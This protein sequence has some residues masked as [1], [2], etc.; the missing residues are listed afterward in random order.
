MAALDWLASQSVSSTT[1]TEYR[2][3]LFFRIYFLQKRLAIIE[4]EKN[5]KYDNNDG[6]ILNV[7]FPFWL[8]VGKLKG[9][10]IIVGII[11]CCRARK[12]ANRWSKK[13]IVKF[14]TP[15]SFMTKIKFN[16]VSKSGD[17]F[18]LRKRNPKRFGFFAILA[19]YAW[20]GPTSQVII[21]WT[22]KLMLPF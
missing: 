7:F 19:R 2:L 14:E 13:K 4:Y 11:L 3:I 8:L 12:G 20:L 5:Y 22:R 16:Y 15:K 6:Q 21:I 1:V 18:R 10:I 17:V 9:Q